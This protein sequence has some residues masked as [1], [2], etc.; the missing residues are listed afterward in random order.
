VGQ[1]STPAG[2]SSDPPTAGTLDELNWMVRDAVVCH[3]DEAA[4]PKVIRL[5]FVRDE[6]MQYEAF[7]LERGWPAL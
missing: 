5:P 1:A 2:G 7:D 6:L 3:F 4:R